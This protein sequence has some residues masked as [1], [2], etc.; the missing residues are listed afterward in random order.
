MSGM[1]LYKYVW[2]T[3]REKQVNKGSDQESKV[4]EGF[5]AVE[6]VN[7]IKVKF[8]IKK[9]FSDP[10]SKKTKKNKTCIVWCLSVDITLLY[11]I[12]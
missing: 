8:F 2:V 7:K 3:G 1:T 10:L 9:I 5:S 12:N 6:L 11:Q 4:A